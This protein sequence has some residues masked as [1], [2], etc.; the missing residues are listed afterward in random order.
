MTNEQK[1]KTTDER[2]RAFWRFCKGQGKRERGCLGCPTK[3]IPSYREKCA[4]AWLALEAEEEK[5][6]HCPFCGGDNIDIFE[7]DF[8]QNEEP[9]QFAVKCKSCG[10]LVSA[11]DKNEAIAAWNRRAK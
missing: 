7:T 1:Y 4:L 11:E 8:G 6:L 5:P 2:I 10:A 3:G 9:Y